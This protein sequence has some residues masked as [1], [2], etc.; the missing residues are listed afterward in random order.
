MIHLQ[1]GIFLK[2]SRIILVV[3]KCQFLRSV[4]HKLSWRVCQVFTQVLLLYTGSRETKSRRTC[5][6]RTNGWSLTQW[7]II[8]NSLPAYLYSFTAIC[9][10]MLT[11]NFWTCCFMFQ[12]PF[13]E[14]RPIKCGWQSPFLLVAAKNVECL[15]SWM[16]RLIGLDHYTSYQKRSLKVT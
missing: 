10:L 8:S 12:S 14:T 11:V 15:A 9:K 16:S 3:R 6:G 4:R 7:F 13:G 2:T 5:T 1:T